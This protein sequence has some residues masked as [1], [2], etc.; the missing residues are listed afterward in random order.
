MHTTDGLR[1]LPRGRGLDDDP[2]QLEGA[3]DLRPANPWAAGN[4]E[5]AAFARTHLAGRDIFE[6]GIAAT[7]GQLTVGHPVIG[8]PLLGTWTRV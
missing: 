6:I 8:I 4:D 5:L 3:L 7:R 2:R 1:L